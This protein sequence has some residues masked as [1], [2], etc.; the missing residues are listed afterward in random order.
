MGPKE[1]LKAARRNVP[2]ALKH[3]HSFY[4]NVVRSV[5]E[6]R[7]PSFLKRISCIS[8]FAVPIVGG[9]IFVINAI[10]HGSY[11][12]VLPS[13]AAAIGLIAFGTVTA[14]KNALKKK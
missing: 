14:I 8:I 13:C 7:T 5:G 9:V 1:Y 10:N 2:F 11:E 4:P 6:K 12:H 3:P